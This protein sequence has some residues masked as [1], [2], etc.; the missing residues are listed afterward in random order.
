M[1]YKLITLPKS[2]ITMPVLT[3]NQKGSIT[4]PDSGL[5]SNSSDSYRLLLQNVADSS[6]TFILHDQ[7]GCFN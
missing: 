5:P 2:T 4:F 1:R 7:I 6:Y 3:I